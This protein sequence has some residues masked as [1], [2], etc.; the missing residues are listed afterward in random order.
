M[1][2]AALT[3]GLLLLASAVSLFPLLWALATSFKTTPNIASFPPQWVPDPVTLEHYRLVAEP[4]GRYIGNSLAV[5]ALTILVTLL[6]A[7]HGAYAAARS[8][9]PWKRTIL[10]LILATMMIPGIAVLIP[11]YIVAARL[12]LFDT[13]SVLVI[14]YGAWMIPMALW[15]LRGFFET[16]PRE[17][18]EAALMD[19]CSRLGTLYRIAMPLVLPGLSA[20]AIV[21]FIYV[22]NEFIIALSMTNAEHLRMVTVGVYYYITA[23]GIEWGKLTAAVCL[24]LLPIISLFLILQR[25]FIRGLTSGA[26]KG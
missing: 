2:R 26:T 13:Y 6:V 4:M 19:G 18:E 20:V 9:F 7:S 1:L 24:A 5:A 12:G 14:I 25:G 16:L 15:L 23:Y 11:L 8:E 3:Y 22:W 10:F 21:V 17:L